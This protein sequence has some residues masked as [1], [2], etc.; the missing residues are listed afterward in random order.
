VIAW[1]RLLRKDLP[2]ESRIKSLWLV[3]V[4]ITELL[5]GTVV[6]Y[7]TEIRAGFNDIAEG[8]YG[9]W[10]KFVGENV[11]YMILPVFVLYA[12]YLQ[13]DY[14]TRRA[15]AAAKPAA[16]VSGETESVAS[17]PA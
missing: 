11:P 9:L 16:L 1:L 13:V 2:D 4:G 3:F 17:V 8:A 12:V 10:F 5:T 15:G 7:V 6:Y 14:L